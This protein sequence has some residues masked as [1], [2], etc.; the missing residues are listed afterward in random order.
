MIRVPAGYMPLIVPYDGVV[1]CALV[2]TCAIS[3]AKQPAP[4][5]L[6]HRYAQRLCST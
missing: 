2:Y 3:I 5:T 6:T 4:Q 1:A